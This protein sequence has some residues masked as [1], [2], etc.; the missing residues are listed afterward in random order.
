MAP[1]QSTREAVVD[2][3]LCQ[4]ARLFRIHGDAAV[5]REHLVARSAS[6]RERIAEMRANRTNGG[7][8]A[9]GVLHQ[10]VSESIDELGHLE[11]VVAALAVPG[12][13]SPAG[14]A[15]AGSTWSPS[16]ARFRWRST[17]PTR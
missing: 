7:D 6:Y 4:R 16:A 8:A 9:T 5:F 13:G 14:R 17:S 10:F 1:Q 12:G 2:D 15:L 11:E 3:P